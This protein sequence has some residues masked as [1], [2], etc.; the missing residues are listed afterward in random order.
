MNIGIFTDTYFPQVNG[1]ATSISL[2]EKELLALGHNVYIF[3]TTD[4]RATASTNGVVR[5]L[6]FLNNLFIKRHFRMDLSGKNAESDHE[7][8]GLASRSNVYRM[9]SVP[10]ASFPDRRVG[11]AY[12]PNMLLKI[13]KLKL[14]IV[15][16]H[17][18]FSLGIF[19]KV[20]SEFLRVPLVHTY[21]VMYEDYVHYVSWGTQKIARNVSRI[22]CNRAK[23]VI[24]PTQKVK[25]CLL[26]YGVKRPIRVIPTGIDFE[27]F[28]SKNY[29]AGETEALR[30]SFGILPHEQVILSLGRV[31][32]EKSID[33]LI[34]GMPAILA[35]LP[36]TKMLIVGDGPA[37]TDLQN[38]AIR[39]GIADRVI[40]AGEQPWAQIGKYYRVGDIFASASSTETQGL[41]YMEAMAAGLSV[42]AK[43]DKSIEKLIRPGETGYTFVN[44]SSFPDI[45][46]KVL[47]DHAGRETVAAQALAAIS[48]MSGRQFAL[49]V[50][51]LYR[52]VMR[53]PRFR[54]SRAVLS[55]VRKHR[56]GK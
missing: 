9:H 41:T 51:E 36:N 4:P 16:T 33:V 56:F 28:R 10:L 20:V 25:D 8:M 21:H 49:K 1:I 45:A 50:E 48:G 12:P 17:T 3:T 42:V 34:A 6:Q 40:F 53:L 43:F 29:S 22:F 27:P 23:A 55:K 39:L 31:A 2:L 35:K 46:V 44:D 52:K 37:R 15:H 18:E 24:C 7:P 54:I 47:A 11:L 19:G 14:D 38:M 32:R 30:K 26:S 5:K 13:R